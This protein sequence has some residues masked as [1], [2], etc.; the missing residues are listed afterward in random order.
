MTQKECLDKQVRS[1]MM[2]RHIKATRWRILWLKRHVKAARRWILWRAR[3]LK[4][5]WSRNQGRKY[6][7]KQASIYAIIYH[8]QKRC[9][10]S[11]GKVYNYWQNYYQN[12]LIN[13]LLRR[14]IYKCLGRSSNSIKWKHCN[15]VYNTNYHN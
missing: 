7:V 1:S 9:R 15:L 4:K 2:Q 11:H 3:S 6:S 14:S 13:H 12:I 5:W 10:S 8:Y